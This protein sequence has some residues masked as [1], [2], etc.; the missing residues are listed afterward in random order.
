M[1]PEAEKACREVVNL[2]LHP[3]VNEKT[4]RRTSDFITRFTQTQ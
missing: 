1:C 4:V 3:R 2:P